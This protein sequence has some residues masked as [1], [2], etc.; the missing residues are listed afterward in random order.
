MARSLT[1]NVILGALAVMLAI[2]MYWVGGSFFAPAVSY[3]QNRASGDPNYRT[4]WYYKMING[5][6]R[7]SGRTCK[8]ESAQGTTTRYNCSK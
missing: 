2:I 7:A 1:K 5:D 3:E 8:E 6:G 4:N